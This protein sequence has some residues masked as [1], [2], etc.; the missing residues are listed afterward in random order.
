MDLFK[1]RNLRTG[2]AILLLS[3]LSMGGA[4]FA[5]S[6]YLQNVLQLNAF[7]TGITTLPM[8]IGLLVFAIFAPSLSS[9]WGHKQLW[10]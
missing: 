10:L 8:T 9:K 2:T 5:V 3:F 1:D 7:N 6:L 4:L